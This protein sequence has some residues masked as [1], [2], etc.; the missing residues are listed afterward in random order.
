MSK[1]IYVNPAWNLGVNESRYDF[2]NLL[3]DDM[4]YDLNVL[5]KLKDRLK[6]GSGLYG[7]IS[8]DENLGQPKNTDCSIDFIELYDCALHHFGQC[9]FIHKADWEP[10]IPG[11]D[12]NF[13]DDFLIHNNL[14]HKR[15]VWLIYNTWQ[16]T[17]PNQTVKDE[18]LVEGFYERERPI[19][20]KWMEEHPVPYVG[21]V[22]T[23]KKK[24]L[25][26]IPT[27]KYIEPDTFKSIYDLEIPDGYEVD[28]QHFYGYNIDQVRNLIADW[29]VKDYDY[30]FAVDSDISFPPD[31]LKKLLSHDAAFITGVYRQRLPGYI[32][33]LYDKDLKRI[34]YNQIPKNKVIE[35]GGCGLGCSL[36]HTSVLKD[37]GY[38]Q[39]E[40]HSAIDHNN[41]F[42][43]DVDFCKKAR[44]I[45]YQIFADTSVVCDHIGSKVF[46]LP[47]D[48][49][50]VEL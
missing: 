19:Y 38:P 14:Y 12:I 15:P 48:R 47:D 40:Y 7:I 31:T 41:T 33:E 49:S 6:P 9:M 28:Y 30:L 36:I 22:D 4:V 32:V 2:I 21:I 29:V 25:I 39:F 46:K 1:N 50:G 42:S 34:E 44:E 17:I 26:A 43:E 23:R 11:L 27:A 3:N 10:I 13:G 35:I 5:D 20:L 45:G 8:G 24:I 18:K 16:G 37:V